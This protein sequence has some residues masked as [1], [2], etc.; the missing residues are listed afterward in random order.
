MSFSASSW[1]FAQMG[2]Y[3]A[4][5]P[6][7]QN[8]ALTGPYLWSNQGQNNAFAIPVGAP[9]CR[10]GANVAQ[11]LMLGDLY[12]QITQTVFTGDGTTTTFSGSLSPPVFNRGYIFDQENHLTSTFYAGYVAAQG[13]LSGG[14]VNNTTGALTLAFGTAPP[15]GDAVYAQYVNVAPYRVQ[16]SAIGDPTNWPVPLTN[17][18]LAFQS[19]YQ[20]LAPAYGQVMYIAGYPLYGLIFQRFGITRANYIGSGAV[21]SFAQYDFTHGL[22][23]HGAV[24]QIA[25]GV[26][27][28]SDDGFFF[29][30]GANVVPIG[31]TSDNSAG[32]D[33]WFW[34]N[35][36]MNALEAIRGGFDTTKRCI[37]FAIPTGS[38]TLPDT[39][40]TFN[41]AAARWTRCAIAVETIWTTDN[42]A[43]NSPGT[44][45]ALGLIDQTHTPNELTGATLTGYLESCDL[46]FVD[47][48]RRLTSGARPQVNCTDTPTITIG[49]RDSLENAVTY[50]PATVPDSFTNT[51]PVLQSGMYTRARVGSGAASSL[52]GTTLYMEQEGEI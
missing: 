13:Y 3:L 33:N 8:A 28:L 39:L 9:G 42:G 48:M 23:A 4:A 6:Y 44:R 52:R 36:N 11:F 50:G 20:D 2:P 19:G 21:F 17:N 41:P 30:D 15:L 12:Q 31:T 47:G 26:F 7:T 25:G 45:Q 16:W 5:I 46:F 1:T 18:A 49:V 14:T 32:I 24:V 51:A 40:L 35:V 37:F 38:N 34:A 29:T 22:V 27:F 43:D 10:V